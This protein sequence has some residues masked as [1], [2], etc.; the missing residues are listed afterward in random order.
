LHD[1][2]GWVGFLNLDIVTELNIKMQ[3]IEQGMDNHLILYIIIPIMDYSKILFLC[4]K[5]S[6]QR[7]SS[8]ELV[9]IQDLLEKCDDFSIL[10]SE[11]GAAYDLL[12]VCPPGIG[13]E[14]KYVIGFID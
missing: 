7:L 14:N 4:N 8:E 3:F 1:L 5:I 9:L 12:I 6:A 13:L 11:P 2:L 10:V